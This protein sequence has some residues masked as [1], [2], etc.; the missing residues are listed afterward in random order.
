MTV[1]SVI[2][3]YGS[4]KFATR[5]LK[6]IRF[7]TDN[8][9]PATTI[10]TPG[11]EGDNQDSSGSAAQSTAVLSQVVRL[12]QTVLALRDDLCVRN[13]ELAMA[14]QQVQSKE[15][16]MRALR[17]AGRTGGEAGRTQEDSSR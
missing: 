11:G 16:E 7:L 14:R 17:T 10:P 2:T 12:Q 9:D 3:H 4:C 15:L 8:V 6:T 5:L 13:C 1:S